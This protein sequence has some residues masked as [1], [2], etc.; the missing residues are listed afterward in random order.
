LVAVMLSV[1][2]T[3]MIPVRRVFLSVLVRW[4]L[5]PGWVKDPRDF[6]L[7]INAR[8]ETAICK[9]SFLAAM[10]HRRMLIPVSGFY[11]L[12]RPPKER[13]ERPQAYWIRPRQ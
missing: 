4:G 11:E 10:R 13:G 3:S 2:T 7:L 1:S 8:S 5:T 6:P 9:A 12:H